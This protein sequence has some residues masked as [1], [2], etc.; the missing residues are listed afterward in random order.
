MLA[1]FTKQTMLSAGAAVAVSLLIENRKWGVA[2]TGSLAAAGLAIA[3]TLNGVTEGRYF[4]NAIHA[5]LNP[6]SLDKLW[7]HAHYFLLTGSG[8]LVGAIFGVPAALRRIQPLYLYTAFAG[9]VWVMTAAKVG[10]DLNYLMEFNLALA[11]CAAVS[12]ARLRFFPSLFESRQ[13]AVTLLGLPLL[14]Y[15]VLNLALSVG[16]SVNRWAL[17]PVKRAER[18]ALG[19][20]LSASRGRV[21]TTSPE[22]L[23]H[24]GGRFEVEPLI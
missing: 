18:E 24:F 3:L 14:L 22:H 7:Q 4:S 15:L 8:L 16:A 11:L 21:I 5:N 1:V 9:A 2:W 13:N 6:F 23:V 12:L 10:S 19:P 17:A 20:Y